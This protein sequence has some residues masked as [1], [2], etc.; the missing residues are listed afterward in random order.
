MSGMSKE[1]NRSAGGGIGI[2]GVVQIVFLILKLC[3][4]I[5]WPWK[6]VLIPLWVDLVIVAVLLIVVIAAAIIQ[7]AKENKEQTRS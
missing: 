3:G 7:V 5:D 2:T 1:R 4:L 6:Y